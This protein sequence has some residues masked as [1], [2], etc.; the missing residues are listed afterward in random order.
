[1]SDEEWNK[2]FEEIAVSQAETAAAQVRNVKEFEKTEALLKNMGIHVGG[3]A[4]SHG[5]STEEYFYNSLFCNRHLGNLK[6]DEISKNLHGKIPNLEDEFDITMFNGSNIALIECKY[7]ATENDVMKL[8]EKKVGNFKALFPF[9]A[10]HNFYLG[11][12]SFSFDDRLEKFAKENGV[13]ILRQKGDVVE[14]DADNLK[15]Y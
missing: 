7:R 9:Y 4:N 11:I 3:M 1:M 2:K 12:A 10:N 6:F 15:V 8:I 13:A 5:Q 14:I